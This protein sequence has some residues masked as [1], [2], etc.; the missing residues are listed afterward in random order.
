MDTKHCKQYVY[1]VVRYTALI[2]KI[3]KNLQCHCK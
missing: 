1:Y 3:Q 2:R